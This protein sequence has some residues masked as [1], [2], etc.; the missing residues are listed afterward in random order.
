MYMRF[1]GHTSSLITF[2]G[3]TAMTSVTSKMKSEVTEMV[4]QLIKYVV[5]AKT[6]VKIMVGC[7]ILQLSKM[8]MMEV[9]KR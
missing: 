3:K 7:T 1:S 5:H 8:I 9:C 4:A 2:T 6:G